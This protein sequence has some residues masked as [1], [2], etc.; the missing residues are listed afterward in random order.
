MIFPLKILSIEPAIRLQ[1]DG[2]RPD[3]GFAT[4]GELAVRYRL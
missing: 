1:D 3:R 4:A 2:P